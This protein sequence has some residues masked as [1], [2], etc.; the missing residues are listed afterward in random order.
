MKTGNTS[1]TMKLQRRDDVIIIKIISRLETFM[2]YF[3]CKASIIGV[4]KYVYIHVTID[5]QNDEKCFRLVI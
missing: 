1:Q 5:L 3:A 4:L 2:A